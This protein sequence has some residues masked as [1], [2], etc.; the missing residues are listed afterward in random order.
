MT[1]RQS[2]SGARR[3]RRLR[4]LALAFGIVSLVPVASASAAPQSR[5]F[6]WDLVTQQFTVPAGVTQVHL[7][8]WGGSGGSGGSRGNRGIYAAPGGLGARIDADVAVNPGATLRIDVGGRGGFG[9]FQTAGDGATAGGSARGGGAGGTVNN[10]NLDGTAGGGGG[11]ATTVRN[12]AGVTV[13]VAGGGGGGAGGGVSIAGNNGGQG[14]DAGSA[15]SGACDPSNGPGTFGHGAGGGAGGNCAA[16]GNGPAGVG[17]SGEA[18]GSGA[19]TGGGGGGGFVGGG[20]GRAGGNGGGGGGGGGAGTSYWSSLTSDAV[21]TNGGPGFGGVVVSWDAAPPAGVRRTKTLGGGD[22]FVV[23]PGVTELTVRATGGSGGRGAAGGE[24][25]VPSRGGYGAAIRGR[26]TVRPGDELAIQTGGVG[27]NGVDSPGQTSPVPGGTAGGG[28]GGAAGAITGSNSTPEEIPNYVGATGGGG[29]GATRVINTT[30]ATTL[31]TAGGGGGGGGSPHGFSTG[32]NGGSG[33][34]AGS[35]LVTGAAA[36]GD[37]LFGSG[38]STPGTANGAGGSFA[39][40]AAADGENAANS[41][42]GN[43]RGTGGGG[44]G[45]VRG[46][47]AGRQCTGGSC[48]G[49]AGGAGAGSSAW[50]GSARDVVLGN[51]LAGNGVV[52]IDWIGKVATTTAIDAS[53]DVIVAG[54]PLTLTATIAGEDVPPGAEPTGTVLFIDQDAGSSLGAPVRLSAGKASL[55]TTLTAG[56]HRVYAA[57][58]GDSLFLASTSPRR[59]QSAVARLSVQAATP[60]PAAV[61]VPYTFTPTVANGTGPFT[62]TLIDGDTPGGI[63][64]SSATGEIFG[65]PTTPGTTEF[66]VRV[67]DSGN[68]RQSADVPVTFVTARALAIDEVT[69]GELTAGSENAIVTVTG[70]SLRPGAELIASDPSIAFSSVDVKDA[71]TLT[72]RVTVSGDVP[73]GVYDVSVKQGTASATCTG[74]LRV[75]A[76]PS[77]PTATPAPTTTPPAPAG[78]TAPPAPPT[79]A[80]APGATAARLTVVRRPVVVRG[81]R[82]RFTVRCTGGACTGQVTG[83]TRR[84]TVTTAR[85][86]LAAGATRTVTLR[87]NRRGRALVTRTRRLPV[88]VTIAQRTGRRLQT[89]SR[90]RVT[91][92]STAGRR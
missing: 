50:V 24:S 36:D 27:G 22:H 80:S 82:V 3:R 60:P 66:T 58:E 68:P 92:R 33:G 21:L 34:N 86:T 41:T 78:D 55:T 19:G 44:G 84:R 85:F 32:V 31:V 43:V 72:A 87:L 76:R 61:G 37:G 20:G 18:P 30:S 4:T 88:A 81:N 59:T 70:Q 49:S 2:L 79:S 75:T 35:P 53:R 83:T 91:L 14:G 48:V 67:T 5:A 63:D 47:A 26:V 28:G 42:V 6:G 38:G 11:G 69:P 52:R 17:G 40:S 10:T 23:P 54:A 71:T 64:F 16:P 62:W 65:I 90:T 57:Y 25:Q 13:L 29:G 56:T 74:C 51:S 8:A 9:F 77:T 1:T 39:S 45:G 73:A 12:A 7:N 46:G 89:I 15:T